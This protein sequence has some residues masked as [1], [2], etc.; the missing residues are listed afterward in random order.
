MEV[1]MEGAVEE[2][3][4]SSPS[5]ESTEST[6]QVDTEKDDPYSSKSSKAYSEWLKAQRE[7]FKDDPNASKF[8]RL[9]KDNHARLYQLQQMEPRG[10]DGIRE[11]YAMLWIQSSTTIQ[12]RHV[13]N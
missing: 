9:S 8:L 1:A 3:I 4:E 11:K 2:I 6:P 12:T 5:G 7:A 13:G 10:I